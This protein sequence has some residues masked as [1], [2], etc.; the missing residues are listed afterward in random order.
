MNSLYI[1]K[2]LAFILI[3]SIGLFTLILI[4]N[5]GEWTPL[6]SSQCHF[7]VCRSP[8]FAYLLKRSFYSFVFYYGIFFI[9]YKN[10]LLCQ[11]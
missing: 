10:Q 4:I 5:S 6:L 2:I 9:N 1:F 7:K 8:S 3:V 11:W